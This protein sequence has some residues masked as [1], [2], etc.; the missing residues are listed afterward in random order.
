MSNGMSTG[1]SN[2]KIYGWRDVLEE[3]NRQLRHT[4]ARRKNLLSAIRIFRRRVKEG[5]PFS[6]SV[7]ISNRN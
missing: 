6:V 1:L 3:A 7:S 4:E 2:T 5:A